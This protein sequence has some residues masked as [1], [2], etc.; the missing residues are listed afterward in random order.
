MNI[1]I[2]SCETLLSHLLSI[3][4]TACFLR[5]TGIMLMCAMII[6]FGFLINRSCQT[7]RLR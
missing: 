2:S 1:L 7:Q 4:K 6:F 3:K 5:Q